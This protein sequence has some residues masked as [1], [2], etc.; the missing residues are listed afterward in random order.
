MFWGGSNCNL[1]ERY[2]RMGNWIGHIWYK[3]APHL[4]I[5]I[6]LREV[7]TVTQ[8][9]LKRKKAKT[10]G[11]ALQ[12]G[13]GIARM[14]NAVCVSSRECVV[15]HFLNKFETRLTKPDKHVKFM[16]ILLMITEKF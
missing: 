16:Y 4:L 7:K 13:T 9:V 11:H 15:K 1:C 2:I 3:S 12:P 14:I 5:Y 8:A 10:L 6:L